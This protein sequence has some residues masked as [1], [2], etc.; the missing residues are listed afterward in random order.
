[1]YSPNARGF[2]RVRFFTLTQCAMHCCIHIDARLFGRIQNLLSFWRMLQ[3]R[4]YYIKI[5]RKIRQKEIFCIDTVERALCEPLLLA[6][7]KDPSTKYKNWYIDYQKY[8]NI[9]IIVEKVR[10]IMKSAFLTNIM[11]WENSNFRCINSVILSFI[12]AFLLPRC[13]FIILLTFILSF[14][15]LCDARRFAAVAIAREWFSPPCHA[16]KKA[17]TDA[18]T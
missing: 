15:L 17:S 12:H 9:Y 7:A 18:K 13:L 5:S 6:K 16:Y 2:P 8:I 11:R 1:M 14:N 3:Y 10:Y 4:V